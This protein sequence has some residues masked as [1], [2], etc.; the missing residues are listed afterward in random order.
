MQNIYQSIV[1]LSFGYDCFVAEADPFSY[2]YIVM[3]CRLWAIY[4]I[5]FTGYA[6][7]MGISLLN[8]LF[9]DTIQAIG[10][11]TFIVLKSNFLD[12]AQTDADTECYYSLVLGDVIYIVY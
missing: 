4:Y 5:G 11:I 1:P 3:L 7:C 2:A 12:A 10:L 9:Y 8:I 6:A